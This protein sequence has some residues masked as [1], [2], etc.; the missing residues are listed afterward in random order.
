MKRSVAPSTLKN[1]AG[2]WRCYRRFCA[3]YGLANLPCTDDQLSMYA[4]FLSSRMSHSSLLVQAVVFVSKLY[5]VNPPSMNHHSVKL[6]SEGA[7][8]SGPGVS[9]GAYPLTLYSL[10][11]LYTGIKFSERIHCVFWASCL[12]MFFSLLRVSHVTESI[13]NLLVRDVKPHSWGLMLCIRSSKTH[14]GDQPILLPVCKLP[15]RRFCP[16]YWLTKL[17]GRVQGSLNEPLFSACLG[18]P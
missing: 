11:K 15:D 18:R 16:V 4:T 5:A 14:R 9:S 1:R 10:K 3:K 7:K 8:H 17:L 2:Q 13:H 12:L 6:V